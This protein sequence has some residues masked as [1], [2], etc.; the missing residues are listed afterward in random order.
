MYPCALGD[1]VARQVEVLHGFAYGDVAGREQPQRL[2]EARLH[3]CTGHGQQWV[4]ATP[5][6]SMLGAGT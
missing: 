5:V 2:F 3:S 6:R 4:T 1:V